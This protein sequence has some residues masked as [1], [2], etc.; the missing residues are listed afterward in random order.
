MT[1]TP[2]AFTKALL[3]WYGE[4]KR[5][6]P[7]RKT[8]DPYAIWVS[9]I[10]LQQ[11]QV[12]RVAGAY[13][14][15]FMAAFPTVQSL[16][17]ATW[18]TVYPLWRG[19]GFYRRG[20]N[21]IKA[22][23]V[24][25]EKWEG[26]FPNDPALLQSL[27]GV[28]AYTSAAIVA[29]AFDEKIPAIDTNIERII[30]ALWPEKDVQKMTAELIKHAPGG[31]DWNGAMMDLASAIRAKTHITGSIGEIM[32]EEICGKIRPKRTKKPRPKGRKKVLIEVGAACIHKD[33]KY[34]L[35]TR[36]EGKSFSGQWEFP[37]GK[38]EKGEDMRACVK[39]EIME[40]LGVEV[41]VRPAFLTLTHE[42]DRVR[43]RLH[44]HRCQIQDGTPSP[45]EGQ[46]IKW[47]A[48]KDFDSVNF[49][50]TN[51]EVVEKLKRMRV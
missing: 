38:R 3:E 36:P 45:T 25:T 40:E 48:P 35:Q 30:T 26:A 42:F 34:L 51:S 11:T 4:H 6:L 2:Q 37:G 16:A 47:V 32:T 9:E 43:L 31:R 50:D 15:K 8:D 29:F 28:G 21:M 39:R 27:P 17:A 10:M 18:K 20:K 1:P 5:D 7:W 33:G 44:F 13:F 49:L 12:P 22:A 24:V 46:E 41:S 19:L 14:P 23:K